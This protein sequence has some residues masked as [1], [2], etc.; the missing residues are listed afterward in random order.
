MMSDRGETHQETM[1]R[2]ERRMPG[3]IERA[4]EYI[5]SAEH[6]GKWLMPGTIEPHEGGAVNLGEGHIR[7]VVTQWQPPHR[8]TYTWNVFSAGET[9]SSFPETYVTFELTADGHEVRLVLT[10]RPIL[11][12]EYEGRTMMGWHTLLDSLV[13]TAQG[14][15][16]ESRDVA[17]ERNRVLYGVEKFTP[18][19]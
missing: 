18:P 8:L 17:M 5:T 13:A 1:I 19:K 4:W 12:K 14:R 11:L 7:G 2:F 9:V 15:E 3:P 16:P 10:H 6:L